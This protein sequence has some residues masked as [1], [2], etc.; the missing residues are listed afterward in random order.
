MLSDS[1]NRQELP[2]HVAIIMDGNGRWA[3]QQ[4]QARVYGH[5]QGV[6][7]LKKI[8]SH[9]AKLGVSS[10]T[11]FAFSSENWSRPEAEISFLMDLFMKALNSEVNELH[12][13]NVTLR[14]IGD[15]TAFSNALIKTIESAEIKTHAN[16]GLLLNVAAN[17]GGR[18]DIVNAIKLMLS[19]KNNINKENISEELLSKYL[20]LNGINNVDLLIRTGGEQRISNFLL[21]QSAYAEIFFSDL[22]HLLNVSLNTGYI[23]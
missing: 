18:W 23:F 14:F 22:A 6:K 11:V 3:K 7:T 13:N 1:N 12:E 16:T 9:A 19:D 10:L 5:R 15:R 20:S 21:W 2:K 4:K 8:V 17:Y